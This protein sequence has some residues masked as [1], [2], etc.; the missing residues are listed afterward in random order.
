[1][2]K[3]LLL[4]DVD[5]TILPYGTPKLTERCHQAF[6]SALEAGHVAGLCTGRSRAQVPP[7]FD[8]DE[9]CYASGVYTNGLS[10]YHQGE[11]VKSW[12][13]SAEEIDALQA[14]IAKVPHAGLLYFEGGTDPLLIEGDQEDMAHYS[15]RYYKMAKPA[16]NPHKAGEKINVFV[17]ADAAGC[18]RVA[19]ILAPALPTLAFDVPQD[20]FLNVMPKGVNKGSS[21]LW[22]ADYLGIEHQNI[23]VFGDADNDL[24]MLNAVENGVAVAGATKNAKAAARW[25]IGECVD[26]AVPAAIEALAAG[27]FPF[28]E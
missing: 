23:V 6:V 22:L 15:T 4:S 13:I 25:H 2:S 17:D 10:I 3:Y 11:L 14:E 28:T 21:A 27:E 18:A 8:F 12:L 16:A 7:F 1:M 24:S 9:R 20:G 26:D 5:G 19:E